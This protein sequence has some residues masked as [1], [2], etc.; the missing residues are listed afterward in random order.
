MGGGLMAH[1][2]ATPIVR[3]PVL[4][5]VC[6]CAFGWTDVRVK[7]VLSASGETAGH[8]GWGHRC[9]MAR[10]SQHAAGCAAP[11][12]PAVDRRTRRSGTF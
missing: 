10:H 9:A 8:W 5:C 7:A 2:F 6:V 1:A 4:W 12:P 11:A 3:R